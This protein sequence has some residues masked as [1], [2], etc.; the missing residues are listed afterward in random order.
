[1]NPSTAFCS[2]V[3]FSACNLGVPVEAIEERELFFEPVDESRGRTVP[4][5]V[6][7]P[8]LDS[9]QPVIL[10]SHGLGGSRNNSAYLGQHWASS[11]YVAVFVQHIGS[12][13][14]V[15]KEVIPG[16]RMKALKEAVGP[17][18]TIDRFS[19]IPFVLDTLQRWNVEEGHALFGR[20]DL[21]H[22]GMTGHSFGALTTQA[23]M[24]QKFP[25]G[26]ETGEPRFDAFLPM[27]P[28]DGSRIRGHEAFGHIESPVLFMTGT[29]DNSPIDPSKNAESRRLPFQSVKEGH[30]FE[31]VFDGGDHLAFSD[32]IAPR[33]E[34]RQPRIHPA[35]L[36]ISTKFWDAYL[37]GDESAKRWLKSEMVKEDAGLSETD[38]WLWK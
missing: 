2:I 26:R 37:R 30:A 15:W 33:G 18:A 9:P 11:G 12:D 1:M 8:K 22:V 7:L 31:L 29:E 34:S 32:R 6:Y 24:G 28:S 17:Q 16:E 25:G 4:V 27:S 19:D 23:M 5:K 14:S 10:F 13:E 3:V 35:I 38:I 21:E 20:L 36:E